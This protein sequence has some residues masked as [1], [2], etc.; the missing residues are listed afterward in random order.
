MSKQLIMISGDHCGY[1]RYIH[2]LAEKLCDDND[3]LF[4]KLQCDNLPDGISRPETLPTFIF[5]VESEMRETWSG[6]NIEKLREKMVN[7]FGSLK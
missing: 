5:R 2:P 4:I 6:S 7:Y 3:I 1:C